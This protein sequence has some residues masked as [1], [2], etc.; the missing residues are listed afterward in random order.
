MA[1]I[2]RSKRFS[3]TVVTSGRGDES[4]EVVTNFGKR[5][6]SRFVIQLNFEGKQNGEL[7]QV[8]F[9]KSEWDRILIAARRPDWIGRIDSPRLDE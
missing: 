7:W 4:V 8:E 3:S 2:R 9:D 6:G 5:L 1:R